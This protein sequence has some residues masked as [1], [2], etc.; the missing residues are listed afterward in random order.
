MYLDMIG[1]A[2]Q[3]KEFEMMVSKRTDKHF[4]GVI[5]YCF[6]GM[7]FKV[8]LDGESRYIAL[9]LLGCKCMVN[10]K[11]QPLMMACAAD[12]LAFAKEN[13]FQRDV[14]VELFS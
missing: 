7:R 3:S 9:S 13:L 5:D 14:T 8:R 6:S 2:K 1:N 11:N 10:D 4:Q 12:A